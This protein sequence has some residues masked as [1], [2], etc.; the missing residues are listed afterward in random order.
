MLRAKVSCVAAQEDRAMVAPLP[1][2]Q[3][4]QA[5]DVPTIAVHI[6]GPNSPDAL[7]ASGGNSDPIARAWR[8]RGANGGRAPPG[9]PCPLSP[10]L[11]V[12]PPVR[13]RIGAGTVP[14]Q[15]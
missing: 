10:R 12:P 13:L 11:P 15:G 5:A 1:Q 4:G 3:T 7:T 14:V 9:T 2:V 6:A 8:E